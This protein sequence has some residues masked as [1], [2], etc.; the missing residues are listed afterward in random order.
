M[1]MAAV[2]TVNSKAKN[3]MYNA[4]SGEEYEKISSCETAKEMWDKLEVTY[5]G[6]N[7]V[8]ETRINLIVRDY[9]LFQMKDGES[10][11]EMFSRFSKILGDLKSLGR[12]IKSGEQVRK[13]LRSLPTIWQPK[14]IALECQDLDKMSYDKLRG[15][16]IAFEKT[17]LDRQIQHKKKKTVSFKANVAELENEEEEEEHDENIAMLSQVV[18]SMMEKNRYSRRGRSNF[19][20]GRMSNEND[21]NDG[22]CYECGKYGHIQADYPELK[23]KLS[24][25]FQKKKSC[26]A[27]SDEEEYDHEEI[28]NMCFMVTK[29][30][31]NKGS[32]K[33]ELMAENE[34]D[35]KEDSDELCLM[36]DKG[37]S[38]VRLPSYSNW[39]KLQEFVDIALTDIENFLGELR[40]IQREKKDWALKLE[41]CEI[42]RDTLQVNEL[43]L[44]LNGL[45]KSTSHSFV[46]SNQIVPHTSLIRTRNSQGCSYCGSKTT[47][48]GLDGG[49]VTFGDKSKGNVIGVEKVSRSSTCDVDEVYL[50]E[51]LGYNLLSLVNYVIM[52][53]RFGSKNMVG[54]LKMNQ[55]KLFSLET[56]TKMFI[57]SVTWKA[58]VIIFVYL[59]ILDDPWA[60]HRKLGHTSM[61]TIHNLYK[62]DLV[63][64]LPKLDFSK[65]QICDACQLGKQTRSS[66]KVKNIVSTSK[67][68]QVL[69]MD[70]F[71]PTRTVSIG[72]KKYAF[73]IVDDFS[74]FTW[75]IFLSHK[76][77]ALQ[78]FKVFCKRNTA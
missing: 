21:K 56:G 11:E 51:E 62:N 50:V 41:V 76:D 15:D 26:G 6:T 5:E 74:K 22:R 30:D 39:Y 20:K 25:N 36:A 53:M 33:P 19:R 68:L 59:S 46:K 75:V 40:K 72:G 52:T 29:K 57:L 49:T 24:R 8:K 70:L 31:N 37:T 18:T 27:W 65:D 48:D 71:G 45:L 10:V 14:V 2:I 16:L 13:I 9:E 73:V 35:E 60:W 64:G 17:H 54:L 61:H 63:I 77:E 12:P 67:P 7:K 34:A 38:E 43:K 55:V 1:R 3:L 78:N 23:K 44:Q 32:D 28:A 47:G 4:I 69:H 66:F 42:K 58:L